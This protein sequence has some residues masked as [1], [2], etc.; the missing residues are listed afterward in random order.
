M[1]RLHRMII[2]VYWGP[3]L[4]TFTIVLFIFSMQW[5]WK[6]VDELMGKGLPFDVIARLIA[7]ATSAFVP[8]VL[9]LAVL[10]SSI[11]TM[12]GLGER[13]ELTPMRSAGLGLFSILR[14]MMVFA[15]LVGG[16]SFY[17]SNNVL[18]VANLK[19]QSLLYDVQRTKP[20]LN[21]KPG[22]FHNGLKG[23]SIRVMG[24]DDEQGTLEDVLIY[25]HRQ[26]F[27]SNR[28]VV[29]AERGVMRRSVDGRFLVL[30][31][32]NGHLYDEQ[33]RG[34]PGRN[35]SLPLL[36]GRF[37]REE[38]RI[39]LSGLGMSRT[40]EELF[41][42]HYKMLTLGQLDYA[43]DSLSM[44]FAER[45]KEQDRYLRNGLAILRD[46]ARKELG[47]GGAVATEEGLKPMPAQEES[48]YAMAVGL[49]RNN[50]T[51]LERTI[52]EREDRAKH[53]SKFRIEWHRKLMLAFAC[54]VFFFIGAPLG[55]IVRKGGLGLPS[56]VAI[57]FFLVFH[58][59][60]DSSEQ[61]VKS[62]DLQAWP[63]MWIG[64]MV[65]LPIGI[66]LTWKAAS[67]S[68]LFDRDAYDRAWTR[69]R[70]RFTRHAHP[71]ALP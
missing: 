38:I 55:A 26:P 47:I 16:F 45:C 15:F 32:E 3:L 11:M 1:K 49:A 36:R 42:D 56:L 30:T 67:D 68:P 60:T 41:R 21:L 24:K 39:D 7:F 63:G 70:A 69:L 51:F 43:E 25:D 48:R 34:G 17:F 22:V 2:G 5:L 44:R 8:A 52:A 28:T 20:A 71:P 64:T 40:D 59:T 9:P 29:R 53:I 10:L 61:L 13:S 66:W 19:F 35:G 33:T 12:G 46:S 62:G 58:I 54:V 14:P 6:W 37:E 23:F 27:Q 65:L 50:I 57:I 31:L 4:V 18:P